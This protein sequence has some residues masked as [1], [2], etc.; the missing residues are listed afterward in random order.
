MESIYISN[1]YSDS[2]EKLF[3]TENTDDNDQSFGQFEQA[4]RNGK[5]RRHLRRAR[6]IVICALAF[7]GLFNI[8]T[9]IIQKHPNTVHHEPDHSHHQHPEPQDLKPESISHE[10]RRS[11]A[12]GSS[13]AEA[14]QLG[15]VYD[16]LSPA[17]VQPYCQDAELTA[18]FETL[19]GGP[20]G[21]WIYY[22]DRNHTQELSMPEVMALADD[23]AARFHFRAKTT[24]IIVEARFDSEGHIRHCAEVFQNRAWKARLVDVYASML[25][26]GSES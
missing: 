2:V 9:Q 25:S 18:E 24:G 23:P 16:S 13:T 1:Y 11:C 7:W 4:E 3:P 6:N 20:N 21:T 26:L 22:A 15:C 5:S 8:I 12:C 19:G 10:P 14:I 17:W